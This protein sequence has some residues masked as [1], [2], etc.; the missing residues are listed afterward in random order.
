MSRK[1][2][3]DQEQQWK[4]SSRVLDSAKGIKDNMLCMEWKGL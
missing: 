2:S 1:F 3:L 4:T